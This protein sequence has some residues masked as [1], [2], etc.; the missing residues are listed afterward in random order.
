MTNEGFRIIAAIIY[1][2]VIVVDIRLLWR[3]IR[4]ANH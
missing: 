2:A 4:Y 1:I 3:V